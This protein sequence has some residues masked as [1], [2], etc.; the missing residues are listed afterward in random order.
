MGVCGA[1][2]VQ[3]RVLRDRALV[4]EDR[5]R[6]LEARTAAGPGMVLPGPSFRAYLRAHDPVLQDRPAT[7][8]R[9]PPAR[10]GR[11]VCRRIQ[12]VRSAPLHTDD[13]SVGRVP[14]SIRLLP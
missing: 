2:R 3:L 11:M 12:T 9:N 6:R 1:V 7:G 14:G 8:L 4:A 13:A 5:G 10:R